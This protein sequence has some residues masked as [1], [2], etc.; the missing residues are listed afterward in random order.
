MPMVPGGESIQDNI[1]SAYLKKG[2]TITKQQTDE[3]SGY[4]RETTSVMKDS[5]KEAVCASCG[6]PAA[7]DVQLKTCSAC[8]MVL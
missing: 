2:Q 8:R 4:W 1:T 5:R 6:K 7:P 3:G